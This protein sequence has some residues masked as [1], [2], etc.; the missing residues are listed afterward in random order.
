MVPS[1]RKNDL[2][3]SRQPR[4]EGPRPPAGHWTLAEVCRRLQA[5]LLRWIGFCPFCY[6]PVSDIA[7]CSGVS[8]MRSSVLAGAEGGVRARREAPQQPALERFEHSARALA[9]PSRSAEEGSQALSNGR[10]LAK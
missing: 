4:S 2:P 8:R 6:Q 1:Q 10:S 7:A 3:P 5:L 9:R